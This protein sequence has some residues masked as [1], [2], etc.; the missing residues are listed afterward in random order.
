[1]LKAFLVFIAFLVQHPAWGEVSHPEVRLWTDSFISE[2]YNTT[3]DRNFNFLGARYDNLQNSE[4]KV[5]AAAQVGLAVDAPLLN[6]VNISELYFQHSQ[7]SVGRK[8]SSW[9]E[10]DARWNLGVWEPVFK[11]NALT[12]ER[13]GLSGVFLTTTNGNW[14]VET[15]ASPLY[16]P[17]QG[18]NFSFNKKG[19]LERLSP[20]FSRP[21]D[22][23]RLTSEGELTSISYNFNRPKETDVV[24]QY[25]LAARVRY[26]QEKGLSV[27]A[28]Y[29]LKPMNQLPLA[30]QG[31]NDIPGDVVQVDVITSIQYHELTGADLIWK[32]E[33]LTFGLSALKDRPIN[34][35]QFENEENWTRPL[36]DEALLFSPYLD[37]KLNKRYGGLFPCGSGNHLVQGP[38]HGPK[39]CNLGG[40]IRLIP[41]IQKTHDFIRETDEVIDRITGGVDL[42]FVQHN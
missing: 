9:S 19:E 1:M 29:A 18:P 10:L 17:D 35:A 22:Y 2:N 14:E 38:G 12:P 21:P 28:S 31:R 8:K 30:Y 25:T 27:Q 40:V 11:W 15:L 42:G 41:G 3:D 7:F 37:V 16:I 39:S 26:N 36:Y 5:K 24:F 13:Q 32:G 4:Q 34:E 23:I 33:A 6:Y 20:W